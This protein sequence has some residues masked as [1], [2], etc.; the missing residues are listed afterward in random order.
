MP[1]PVVV[2]NPDGTVQVVSPTMSA[3]SPAA[4]GAQQA[5]P[6]APPVQG[7]TPASPGVAGA[8][9]DMIGALAKAFAPK[10]ITQRGKR[11]DQAVNEASGAPQ[12][13]DLGDQ[14]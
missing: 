12:T 5:P 13:S 10:A 3:F 4:A 1:N 9:S 14:F 2:R 6:P 11:I 7:Q 8:I